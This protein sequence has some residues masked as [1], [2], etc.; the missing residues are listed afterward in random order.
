MNKNI[1]FSII[2]TAL[3]FMG[4]ENKAG[5]GHATT[6]SNAAMVRT[7]IDQQTKDLTNIYYEVYKSGYEDGRKNKIT[8]KAAI[9]GIC[10]ANADVAFSFNMILFN[11]K[12][13]LNKDFMHQ[14]CVQGIY[15]GMENK[16]AME[17]ISIQN[18]L[19]KSNR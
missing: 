11:G 3:F 16:L 19:L 7:A 13:S 2:T 6:D 4:C 1:I 8:S 12:Y 17:P 14:L 15:D 18:I 9:Y 5:E 10:D